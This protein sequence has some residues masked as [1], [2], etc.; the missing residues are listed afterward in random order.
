MACVI[1]SDTTGAIDDCNGHSTALDYS[2]LL[3]ISSAHFMLPALYFAC[4]NTHRQAQWPAELWEVARQIALINHN[5]N[6]SL[7]A[8]AQ[9]IAACFNKAGISYVFL[10]GTALLLGGYYK[11]EGERMVGDID[12]LVAPHQVAQSYAL[13]QSHLNYSVSEH[14]KHLSEQHHHLPRLIQPEALAAVEIHKTVA[15]KPLHSTLQTRRLLREKQQIDTVYIPGPTA[16]IWHNAQHFFTN[17]SG[18]IGK[19]VPNFRS[20]Q[21]L[22]AVLRHHPALYKLF[23][24]YPH[25][26]V[27][28]THHSVYSSYFKS[29]RPHIAYLLQLRMRYRWFSIMWQE[30]FMLLT[31]IRLLFISQ[32]YRTKLWKMVRGRKDDV[33]Y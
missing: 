17:N 14:D 33:R 19:L 20:Y 12:V 11:H 30:G 13:L 3:H 5:R 27:F 28:A 23:E 15:K 16:L 24:V 8:Q 2:R 1:A 18:Y 9:Q 32:T 25:L 29:Y 6:Q 10:K 7:I 21:D 4:N 31:R 26:Q 22:M